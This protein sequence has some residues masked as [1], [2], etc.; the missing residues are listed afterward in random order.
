MPEVL[1]I[2]G[3]KQLVS[4]IHHQALSFIIYA[5]HAQDSLGWFTTT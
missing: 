2:Y 3:N 4:G 1:K 5:S